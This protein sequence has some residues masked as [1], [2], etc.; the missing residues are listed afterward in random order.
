MWRLT[1]YGIK[2]PI[3]GKPL[4]QYADRLFEREAF[5]TSLSA[6]EKEYHAA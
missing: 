4:Q 6:V 2:L 3:S 5:N 1:Q